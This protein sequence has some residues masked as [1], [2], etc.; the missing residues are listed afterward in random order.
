MR[1]LA[2]EPPFFWPQCGQK[3]GL[4]LAKVP[5]TV[6]P[7]A[8]QDVRKGK[9]LSKGAPRVFGNAPIPR[10]RVAEVPFATRK[11]RSALHLTDGSPLSS[12]LSALKPPPFRKAL[13]VDGLRLIFYSRPSKRLIPSLLS[14]PRCQNPH[15][16]R[17]RL[18]RTISCATVPSCTFAACLP[19]LRPA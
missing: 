8:L 13:S 18:L 12:S 1:L 16:A 4:R 5:A 7:R 14:S 2:T 6:S 17:H 11:T 15:R 3:G 19:R 9:S 10:L